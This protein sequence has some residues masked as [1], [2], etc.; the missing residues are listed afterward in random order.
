MP[1]PTFRDPT[2]LRRALTHR[3]YLNENIAAR[4]ES[5]NER[6]EFLGD[7]V[8]D[9]IAGA[10]LFE[11][12]PRL[13]EGKLTTLRAALVRVSTLAVFSREIGIPDQ[14]RMGKG[15]L[16]TGGRERNNIIGDAFEA[17]L[18]ALYL[19]QGIDACRAFVVPFLERATPAIVSHNADRDPKSKLQEWSQG[20]LN[21]TPRYRMTGTTGP[22]H[23]KTFHVEVWLGE[24]MVAQA[25]GLS[26]QI[27]EQQ[28][29]RDALELAQ[30]MQ[31]AGE[32]DP[33]IDA[34]HPNS[35]DLTGAA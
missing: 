4:A 28:A 14:M 27:A 32:P 12:F 33:T 31:A 13:D 11:T 35:D 9:F 21:V 25:T 26:K 34:A 17:V 1:I 8:L 29:A 23:E 19:D 20:V 2:L 10:W 7:A 15:E 6:L 22:D 30:Q 16:D 18:G 3:S 24:T 5:H